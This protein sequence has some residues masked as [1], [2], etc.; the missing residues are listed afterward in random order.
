MIPFSLRLA[1]ALWLVAPLLPAAPPNFVLINIDDLGYADIG[2]FGST[3]NRTPHLDRM[4]AEGRKL[5][6]HY[7]APVCSPSRAAML[8]GCYPGRALPIPH[9]LFP[10]SAVGLHPDEITIADLLRTRGYAT[11]CIGK[12]HLG[13]QPGMLPTDQGF[14]TYFGI[15][16]SNDMGTAE[17]GAKSNPGD[18]PKPRPA[19][20]KPGPDRDETGLKGNSQPP[21]PLLRGRTVI[22]RVR[23]DGQT[24]ITRRYTEEAVAF[25]QARAAEPGKP[26]FLYLPHTAVHFP[27]Y[28]GLEFR[29][30]SANGL[31]GDW[32]EEVDWSVGRVLD[33]LRSLGL[34]R[35]TLVIFTSDN[36]GTPKSSNAP[37]RGHKGSTWEGGIRVC[38]L[39]WWPGR[40]PA[41]TATDAI[42]SHLDL[43]PT[44]ANLAG[45]AVPS[46]RKIDGVDLW[47]AL[48][49][50]AR[51]R[52]EFHYYR[53]PTLQAVR[54]ERW[55]LHLQS[56]QLH[57]LET[58]P[59]EAVDLASA[60]PDHVTRLRALAAAMESD[61]GT[62]SFGPGCRPLG[63]VADPEPLLR[64]DGSIR[65]GFAPP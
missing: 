45:A 35:S 25:L 39:A 46:D 48:I 41:G 21:L 28:P 18:T 58:D 60:H 5:T 20:A 10:A 57:D 64:H 53:G 12:W 7:A 49:G 2:P 14:D 11:A 54:S 34:D 42:T 19:N 30:R 65:P 26:F 22:E 16:Y 8:T 38:T 23:Q 29:S 17:D 32:V 24:T 3:L 63:R 47:P 6:S 59:G 33:T 4:A 43:L 1:A 62:T 27:L 9:V 50:D 52:S 51:P 36:G 44:F 61:V 13:D 31:L 15:P 37:L 40:I 55:K 56:G